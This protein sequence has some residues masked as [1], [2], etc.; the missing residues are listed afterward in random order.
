MSLWFLFPHR[1]VSR[2]AFK[3]QN[4]MLFWFFCLSENSHHQHCFEAYLTTDIQTWS[5]KAKKKL[6]WWRYNVIRADVPSPDEDAPH[7]PPSLTIHRWMFPRLQVG[8]ALRI[9]SVLIIW[10][11]NSTADCRS[12]G[13][14]AARVPSPPPLL[15][16]CYACRFS[17]VCS[18]LLDVMR[19]LMDCR[20]LFGPR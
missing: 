20:D 12:H 13:M 15:L 14:F 6:E 17:S 2:S 16:I 18:A 7:P 5:M 8:K 9:L 10:F 11:C 4:T 3:H 1:G 19:L